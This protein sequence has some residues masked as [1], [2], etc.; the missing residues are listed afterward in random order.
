M[1]D[2]DRIG[3][4]AARANQ[5]RFA[6]RIAGSIAWFAP[7]DTEAMADKGSTVEQR[8]ALSC[9]RRQQIAKLGLDFG[10]VFH[11]LGDFDANEFPIALA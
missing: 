4:K 11:G 6:S 8:I 2:D 9:Q 10:L 3:D 5:P 7:P 1:E